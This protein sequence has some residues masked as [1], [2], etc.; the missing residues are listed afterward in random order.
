[1]PAK[2]KAD[3]LLIHA[4][5]LVTVA[6]ASDVPK[7]GDSLAE[8]GVVA[9]GAVAV[10][11]GVITSVGTTDDVLEQVELHPGTKVLNASGRVVL[12]GLVDSHTNLVFAGS[13]EHE[14]SLKIQGMSYLEILKAGGGI[15]STVWSTR[16]ASKEEL[17]RTA[18]IYLDQ[19]LCQGTT[20]A[21]VK[22][23]YGLTVVDELKILEVIRELDRSHSLDL[24]PTF[25]GAHAVPEEYRGDPEGYLTLI[26]DEML[27]EVT[28]LGLAEFC[29][30]FCEEGAFSVDQSRRLLLAAKDMGLK[31]KI[32]A[33]GIASLGGGELA[34][35]I[36]AV[37][38]GHLIAVS[39]EGIR[40]L[41][42]SETVAVLLPTATFCLMTGRYA[43]AVKMIREG[44][45]V[46]LASDFNP[47]SSPVNSLPVVLGIAC[48]QF[49]MTPAEVI[50]AATINAAHAIGRASEIGSIEAGKKADLV[51]FDAPSYSYLPYRFGTNLVKTVI[52]NGK[53]VVDQL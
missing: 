36:G 46:A 44:V 33:D 24:V 16:F 42:K 53:V 52:K 10:K 9:D 5:Q 19:M 35:E 21:E 29:D 2:Q 38:A 43:P 20:T 30:V 15:L 4:G 28:A 12:P 23:G 31:P 17:Y 47:G 14:F 45:A 13:R 22:S 3:L 32:H 26:V 34:A 49:R 50:S 27:P 8:I 18:R 7:R 1:M 48:R 11:D 25:L 41:A 40:R 37:S 51:V 6:G 39:E